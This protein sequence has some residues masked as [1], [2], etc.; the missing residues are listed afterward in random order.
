MS[1][2]AGAATAAEE[3]IINHVRAHGMVAPL[4]TNDL[5]VLQQ[6]GVSSRVIQV[7][8]APPIAQPAVV[9]VPGPTPVIVE[10]R[11]VGPYWGPPPYWRYHYHHHPRPRSGMS[12]GVSIAN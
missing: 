8:Q 2:V 12:W 10:E 6:Q 9:A 1:E 7:M 4:Q 11:Y 5:I 3:L